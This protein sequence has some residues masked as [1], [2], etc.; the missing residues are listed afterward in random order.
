MVVAMRS[1]WPFRHP[2]A[3][4]LTGLQNGYYGFLAVLG[5]NRQLDLTLLDVKNRIR[6]LA[7]RKNR[8]ISLIF[9]YGFP[10]ADL[11]EKFLRIKRNLASL[12]TAPLHGADDSHDA[13]W[14]FRASIG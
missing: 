12:P 10:F 9:G 8:L 7:L 14:D 11:G 3:K 4:K 6:D 2:F 5:D 13:V 1:S